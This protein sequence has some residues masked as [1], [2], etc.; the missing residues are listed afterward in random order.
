MIDFIDSSLFFILT[1]VLAMLSDDEEGQ[2]ETW[3]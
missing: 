2:A 1:V 3:S